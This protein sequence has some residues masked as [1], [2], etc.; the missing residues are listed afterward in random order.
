MFV[1]KNIEFHTYRH[2]RAREMDR[3]KQ[4]DEQE[5]LERLEREFQDKL[6]KDHQEIT[7]KTDKNRKK[8]QR[9]KEAKLR[10]KNL[11]L[12]GVAAEIVQAQDGERTRTCSSTKDNHDNSNNN[13]N[14]ND[15][16]E[17]EFT[18]QPQS[19]EEIVRNKELDSEATIG[20]VKLA[21]VPN[22]EAKEL[23]NTSEDQEKATMGDPDGE[24]R[25]QKRQAT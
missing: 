19:H 10:K 9:Q 20:H 8:R 23:C 16:D 5:T 7:A 6:D 25:P 22:M 3:W 4:I 18:Y 17:E 15:D 2:A 13:N 21:A 11:K 1:F 24:E 12:S 14:N